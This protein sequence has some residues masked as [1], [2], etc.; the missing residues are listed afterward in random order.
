VIVVQPHNAKHAYLSS[1]QD[2]Q[3]PLPEYLVYVD[4]PNTNPRHK[5]VLRKRAVGRQPRLRSGCA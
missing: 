4:L 2:N 5:V 3:A 1:M